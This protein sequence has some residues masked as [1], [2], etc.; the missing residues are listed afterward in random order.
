VLNTGI[1]RT[2]HAAR[3]KSINP[4]FKGIDIQIIS[5]SYIFFEVVLV[6][7]SI[8]VEFEVD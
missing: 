4:N 1:L 6:T 8:V 3:L 5:V 7:S 2:E